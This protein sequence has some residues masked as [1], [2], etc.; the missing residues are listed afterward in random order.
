MFADPEM[1]L[2]HFVPISSTGE[3]THVTGV[4][5]AILGCHGNGPYGWRQ[6]NH[7]VHSQP[8]HI[9]THTR[10]SC[11]NGPTPQTTLPANN[12]WVA[13]YYCSAGKNCL[14]PPPSSLLA[15][16]FFTFFFLKQT[17]VEGS[18]RAS[19]PLRFVYRDRSFINWYQ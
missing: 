4:D 5:D 19:S 6:I 14:L 7:S 11:V 13:S 2:S 3:S 17:C 9:H 16:Y 1:D 10:A 12:A 8:A 18:L 15:R